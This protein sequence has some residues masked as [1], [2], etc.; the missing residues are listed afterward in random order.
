MLVE[1]LQP[2]G[3][4][5]GVNNAI[6]IAL[7]AKSEH[8]DKEAYVLGM[9]V[10]NNF[11]VNALEKKGIHTALDINDIPEGEV[12]IYTAHGHDKRLDQIATEKSLIIYDA[13]CPK[14]RSN[15]LLIEKELKDNHQIIYIGLSG[16]PETVGA[17]S[18]DSNVLLYDV[19]KGFDYALLKDNSPLVIN[20]TTLNVMEL[21]D[22][23]KD[24]LSRV[25]GARITDEI[26]SSTRKRQEAIKE[27]GDDVDMI[28]VVGDQKSSNSNR[29]LEVAKLSHP[30]IESIMISDASGLDVERI[31]N[32]KHIV[33][34]SGAST[35]D[36]IIDA[37]YDK[38]NSLN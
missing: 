10:H 12:I 21:K 24:I 37:I 26:C 36:E 6:R 8:P 3:Y 25:P 38:I 19:K 16:H 11:V 30:Q 28:I 15:H 33:I 32:K 29:L 5:A 22:I 1:I 7:T 9:L 14:V 13:V 17:I 18:V 20:Q 31:R 35:P 27:I 23:H 34:S 4:C 2:R